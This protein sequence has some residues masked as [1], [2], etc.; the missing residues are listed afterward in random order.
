MPDVEASN[1]IYFY[2]MYS[3]SYLVSVICRN[4]ENEVTTTKTGEEQTQLLN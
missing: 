1:D 4:H 2:H 3:S